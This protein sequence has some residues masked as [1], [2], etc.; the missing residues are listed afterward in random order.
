MLRFSPTTHI[1]HKIRFFCEWRDHEWRKG[2]SLF[3]C[4]RT[5]SFL[6]SLIP[7]S[8]YAFK[9]TTMMMVSSE[10]CVTKGK[11]GI[12]WR[13][14]RAARSNKWNEKNGNSTT[15][16]LS[17]CHFW[18][19][20]VNFSSQTFGLPLTVSFA[21]WGG[22]SSF[23]SIVIPPTLLTFLLNINQQQKKHLHLRLKV[24]NQIIHLFFG[25]F[26]VLLMLLLCYLLSDFLKKKHNFLINF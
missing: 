25:N 7:F 3:L 9:T 6:H 18:I 10:F 17:L 20:F 23:H 15:F 4:V 12:V 11:R 21:H 5:Q 2:S 16:F 13:V 8:G 22:I 26:I 19:N 24:W 1:R 14:P